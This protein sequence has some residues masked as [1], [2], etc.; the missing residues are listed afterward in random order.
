MCFGCSKEPFHRDSSFEYP[1]HMF[2][3]R[4]KKNNFSVTHSY[5]G[6]RIHNVISIPEATSCDKS[7]NGFRDQ[8]AIAEVYVI[9][10]MIQLVPSK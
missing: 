6:A 10:S 7:I 3:L 4:N 1:Q 5:L 2:W 9:V 8:K